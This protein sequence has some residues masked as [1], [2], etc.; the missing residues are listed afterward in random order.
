MAAGL[1]CLVTIDD[2]AENACVEAATK[3]VFP[4]SVWIGYSQAASGPEPLGGWTWRCGASS[5]LPA[6]WGLIEPNDEDGNEDCASMVSG[7]AWLD[8]SCSTPL[9]FVCELPTN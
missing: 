2:A 9:R 7:G 3:P 1:G 6:N 4:E 8:S 5:F